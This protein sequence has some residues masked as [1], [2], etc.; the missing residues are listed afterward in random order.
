M[1]NCPGKSAEFFT[2]RSMAESFF[3][4]P[5]HISK[6]SIFRLSLL[7]CVTTPNKANLINK[8]M[9]EIVLLVTLVVASI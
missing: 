5:V 2:V 3:H 1:M 4:K 8:V 6:R 7:A 9:I